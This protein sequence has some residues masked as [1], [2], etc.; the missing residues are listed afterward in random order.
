MTLFCSYKQQELGF[1]FPIFPGIR[2]QTLQ[3]RTTLLP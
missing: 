2:T 1:F 3:D